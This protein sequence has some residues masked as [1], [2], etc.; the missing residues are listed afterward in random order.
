MLDSAVE[1]ATA[2]N[3]VEISP[4][5]TFRN[6]PPSVGT[7]PDSL[8]GVLGAASVVLPGLPKPPHGCATRLT[9]PSC[10]R[11]GER[12]HRVRAARPGI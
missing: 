7:V 1:Y 11:A 2:R 10:R 5:F 6:A 4:E 12:A 8:P 9:S 3:A